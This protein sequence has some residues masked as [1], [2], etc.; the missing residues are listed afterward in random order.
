MSTDDAFSPLDPGDEALVATLLEPG[1]R[2]R[3]AAPASATMQRAGI[4]AVAWAL[5]ALAISWWPLRTAWAHLH[6]TADRPRD[7]AP[8]L[9]FTG[10][11]LFW[12]IVAL[13][14]L[15]EPWRLHRLYPHVLHLLTDR[16]FLAIDRRSGPFQA[17]Q[18]DA[19]WRTKTFSPLGR[20][21]IWRS[22]FATGLGERARVRDFNGVRDVD[23]VAQL[24]ADQSGVP[25][26]LGEAQVAASMARMPPGRGL[27]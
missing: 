23:R 22:G 17:V 18:L 7:G 10:F 3:H 14:L 21:T 24:I 20:L 4:V 19:I 25:V 27:R 8:F 11:G 13:R 16:R 6:A 5:P 15:V 9:L 2:V 26:G 1:E 12:I